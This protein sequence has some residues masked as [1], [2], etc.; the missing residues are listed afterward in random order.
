MKALSILQPTAYLAGVLLG[1]GWLSKPSKNAKYGYLCLRCKDRDF[2]ETFAGAIGD[3]FSTN[4]KVKVDERGYFLVRRYNTGNQFAILGGY[5][6]IGLEQKAA[7][8][9]GFFDSEGC[10]SFDK[11]PGGPNSWNRRICFAGTNERTLAMASRLLR[12]LNIRCV[13]SKQKAS[14]GHIGKKQ[15]FLLIITGG[16]E[17]IGRFCSSVGTSIGRKRLLMERLVDSY[18]SQDDLTDVALRMQKV[19]ATKRRWNGLADA[20]EKL[21]LVLGE[22]RRMKSS[23]TKPTLRRC[24][25][26]QGYGTVQRHFLHSDLLSM[27]GE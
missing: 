21:P 22:M 5:E 18:F 24:A 14:N 7:W 11:R 26:I 8:L 13:V 12:D 27:I 20:L 10:V 15:V 23:G 19:G 25:S 2:A 3:A 16:Q 17:F 9:Q 6:P 1:D 4:A